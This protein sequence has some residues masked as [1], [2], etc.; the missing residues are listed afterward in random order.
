M[1]TNSRYRLDIPIPIFRKRVKSDEEITVAKRASEAPSTWREW[2]TTMLPTYF[3]KPFG[4]PHERMFEWAWNIKKNESPQAF[5]DIRA[6]HGGKSVCAES[7]VVASAAR[8]L[9]SYFLYVCRTQD[10]ADKHVGSIAGML[11]SPAI[12][13]FYPRLSQRAVSRYGASKGWRRDRL[14]TKSGAVIDALGLDVAARG[15]RFEERRPDFIVFDDIDDL[16][17]GP[18]R[19]Q[20]VIDTITNTIIPAGTDNTAVLFVQNLIH[21]NSVC[22][23]LSNTGEGG[24]KFL[25]Q[26]TVSGPYPAIYD[27]EYTLQAK[28][29]GSGS[30]YVITGGIPVWEGQDIA[31]CQRIMNDIGERSFLRECQHEVFDPEDALWRMDTIEANRVVTPPELG[32]RVVCVDPSTTSNVDSAECGIVVGGRSEHM[33]AYILA[34]L[35]KRCPPTEWA[36]IVVNAVKEYEASYVVYEDN[37]G[38]DIVR[39]MI[40]LVDPSIVCRPVRAYKSKKIRAEPVSELY[41]QGRVHHVG[42]FS[43]LERQMCTWLPD[44]NVSPDRMDAAVHL[45]SDLI[46]RPKAGI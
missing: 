2:L 32:K 35:S 30:E 19:I 44:S 5:I 46:G 10:Q 40:N 43:K 6:R 9:R 20:K 28:S 12:E 15:I 11:G 37:Q 18:R 27:L 29:D 1:I 39:S 14:V 17:D 41:M 25:M 38:G 4:P 22:T 7:T 36:R 23:L 26:R 24:A 16:N 33:H 34:D 31:R 8:G 42:A 21:A 45:V 13:Y 3:T